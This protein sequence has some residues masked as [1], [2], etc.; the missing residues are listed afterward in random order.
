MTARR[1]SLMQPP[2]HALTFV[3]RRTRGAGVLR[4]AVALARI[5]ALAAAHPAAAQSS[6]PTSTFTST[7][8][9]TST[10]TATPGETRA[11]PG[12]E[13]GASCDMTET[14]A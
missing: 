2:R 13:A 3:A 1:C 11:F 4:G 8:L 6:T 10:C 7:A 14:E 9:P 5:A 12:R